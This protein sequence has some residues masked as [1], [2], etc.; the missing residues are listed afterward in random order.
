MNRL[1]YINKIKLFDGLSAENKDKLS[2]IASEEECRKKAFLFH[3]GETGSAVY[4]LIYGDIQL[5]KTSPEGKEVVIKVIKPGELFAEV[6]LFEE[7]QYPVTAQAIS[8]SLVL[9]LPKREV[10]QLL[11]LPEFRNDFIAVLMRKQRYLSQRIHYLSAYNLDER[12]RMFLLER[13]GRKDEIL[14][15]LSKKD[16][17]AAIG[18]TPE[19]LSRLLVRLEKDGLLHWEK[20]DIRISPAFWE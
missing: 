11:D 8:D 9:V 1:N 6:I 14:C 2:A 16:I 12:L 7:N 5:H 18:A 4:L 3:E 20:Q 13:F 10:L 15:A 17:A 19:S